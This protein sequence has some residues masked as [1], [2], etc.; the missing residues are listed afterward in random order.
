MGRLRDTLITSLCTLLALAF[1]PFLNPCTI[2]PEPAI[3][4]LKPCCLGDLLLATA[5]IAA[6][7]ESYPTSRIALA[8]GLWSRPAVEHSPDLTE[9]LDC[10]GTAGRVGL[11]DLWPLAASLRKAHFDVAVVLDR[12]PLVTFLPFLAGIPVRAGLDSQHRGFSLTHPVATRLARHEAQLY[13][14][15]AGAV[16]AQGRGLAR[17]D[18]SRPA[19]KYTV[20][21]EGHAWAAEMMDQDDTWIAVHPGGGVNPGRS[22]LGKRWPAERYAA[23]VKRLLDRDYS[24]LLLG[25]ADDKP[26]VETITAEVARRHQPTPAGRRRGR[27]LDMSGRTTFSQLGALLERCRLFL[28][29]DTGPM[30]LAVA[31]GTPVVAVFGP[32]QPAIYGPFTPDAAVVYHGEQCATCVFQG[33]LVSRCN[34]GYACMAAV[35]VEE[36]WEAVEAKLRKPATAPS[37]ERLPAGEAG[38]LPASEPDAT[39]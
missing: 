33:G 3:L 5:A 19:L 39:I 25:G 16:G 37:S 27:L 21:E 36:V 22:L 38:S 7:R 29:N 26:L 31:V 15:A 9:V 12:S 10:G 32:S 28:G 23:I 13:L 8:T 2:P 20:S 4:V 18:A 17:G 24:V 14:E 6:L 34:N 35:T 30:H 11:L 1:K